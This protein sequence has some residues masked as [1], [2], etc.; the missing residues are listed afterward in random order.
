[1]A[2]AYADLRIYSVARV[3]DIERSALQSL[4]AGTLM[5]RAGA[6]TA[7]LALNMLAPDSKDPVLVLAGPGNNGGD[8][9]EAAARLS[10]HGVSVLAVLMADPQRLPTDALNAYQRAVDA[11]VKFVDRFDVTA[12][13]ALAIDGLFGIGLARELAGPFAAAVEQL[14]A[15]ECKVLAIDVPSGLDADSGRV[16]G[17]GVAVKADTTL[18]FIADKPGLHTG[19]GRDYAGQ[20]LVDT[21][22]LDVDDYGAPLAR[23]ITPALFPQLFTARPHASHKGSFGDVSVIGGSPGMGG[24][25]LLAA[26]MAAMAG[27]GRVFAAFAGTPPAF[28]PVHPELM[29][30]DAHALDWHHGAFVIG[31][32]LGTARDAHDLV[33]TALASQRPLVIDADALNLIAQEYGLQQRLARRRAPSLLTPHPAEAARLMGSD[34]SKVQDNRLSVAAELASRF[35]ACVI[36]KGSGSI[37]AAPDGRLAINSTGNP[38]LATAGSGDVL[39][40]LCGALLAQQHPTWETALAAVWLHGAAADQMVAEGIGPVGVTASELLPY[41][42]RCLNQTPR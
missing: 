26:R 27:A 23:L 11:K 37:V 35:N 12:R 4:P 31:P 25:V 6:A 21:L 40:G 41:I 3:R 7:E 30:R 28:D 33:A 42:R 20:V 29:C 16:L 39:A 15:L 32:G 8:A 2:T 36:L 18:S 13:W 38:A 5:S 19:A 1:M 10:E 14:N 24:A 34:T 17:G 9:L 22:G